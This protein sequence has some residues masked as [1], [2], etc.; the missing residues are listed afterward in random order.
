[1]DCSTCGAANPAQAK[2]CHNCG[3]KLLSPC[4]NCGAEQP[5]AARFCSNCG[6]KLGEGTP[7]APPP[8][9]TGA[10][11]DRFI[12][13]ALLQKL[14]AARAAGQMVGERRVVTMLFCDVTGSTA[15][16][17]RER[18]RASHGGNRRAVSG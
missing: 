8:L 5:P 15:A 17:R 2:F 16:A 4:S 11:L 6:Y 3:A 9:L 12:P 10:N 1:M 13:D 14:D 7:P 18:S